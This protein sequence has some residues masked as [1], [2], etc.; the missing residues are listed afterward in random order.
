MRGL[1]AILCLAAIS[2]CAQSWQV[3]KHPNG[4]RMAIQVDSVIISDFVYTEVSELSEGKAYVA[5]GELYA[6][7]NERGEELTPYVFTV[8]TN[9]QNGFAIVGDSSTQSVIDDSMQLIFPLEYARV[10]L[11]VLGLIVVQSLQGDWGVVDID[12]NVKLPCIYDL[13][14]HVINRDCIIV[15]KNEEYGVVN[16]C[17]MVVHTMGYQY[18]SPDGLG[19]KSGK[20]LRLFE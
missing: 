6:Y 8:A 18:I 2:C 19:Y 20:Y 12:G 1:T 10:R 11:P 14:P 17:N 16:D 13:P 5:Q 3:K 4:K 7:I 9:F 15:R